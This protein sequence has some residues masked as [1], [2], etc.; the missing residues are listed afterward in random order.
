MKQHNSYIQKLLQRQISHRR[1]KWSNPCAICNQKPAYRGHN[2]VYF[3]CK[4]SLREWFEKFQYNGGVSGRLNP[5]FYWLLTGKTI[6]TY[7]AASRIHTHLSESSAKKFL[8]PREGGVGEPH[9]SRRHTEWERC[10]PSHI[11]SPAFRSFTASGRL[12][13]L[14]FDF[15]LFTQ[16]MIDYL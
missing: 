5:E 15:H 11:C 1:K 4:C 16:A 2:E 3:R 8:V 12:G 14:P 13:F 6:N 10:A 9:Q 7:F